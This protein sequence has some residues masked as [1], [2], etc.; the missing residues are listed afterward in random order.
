[1]KKRAIFFPITL[2]AFFAGTVLSNPLTIQEQGSFAAGGAV[3]TSPGNF[4]PEAGFSNLGKSSKDGHAGQTIH[5]D[6]ATVSY[7]IPPKAR[8]LPLIFLHG[9]GQS[10]RTWDTTPDGREGFRTIF[11]RKGFGIYVVDQPRRGQSGRA[12]VDGVVKAQADDQ[13]WF[14]QFRIGQWPNYYEGVQFPRDKNSLNQF[15]RQMT[16]NT[17]A[18]APEVNTDAMKAVFERTG[19]GILVTH[20]QGGGQGWL[21]AIKSTHVKAIVSYEP[22]SD[23][24]FPENE[25]PAPLTSKV[26]TL[27]GKPVPM[28]SFLKLTKIPIVIYYGDFIATKSGGYYG[29]DAWRTRLQMARL[30]ADTVNR[31][32]GDVTVVHLP[33]LGIKGN[34]HFPFSDLNNLEIAKLM[35]EWLQSKK[36]D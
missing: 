36:L 14:G 21:T 34:T 8:P 27:R 32:G 10:M 12:L 15:F 5:G 9:A 4:N 23:F 3:V 24:V 35:E 18:Y 16:P 11:L 29:Q 17:A 22:G 31:Y 28:E 6:H 1:M 30:W 2:A 19:D 33:E 7:Q 25:L 13:F 26:D 20:S